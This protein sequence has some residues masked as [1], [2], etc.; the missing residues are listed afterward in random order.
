[1]KKIPKSPTFKRG[2]RV[3]T[4]GKQYGTVLRVAEL[5]ATV[6]LDKGG[7]VGRI[8]LGSL[9]KAR[10]R[11]VTE[12]APL[13]ESMQEALRRL[14]DYG[15]YLVAA[16]RHAGELRASTWYIASDF[17]GRRLQLRPVPRQ[18]VLALSRRRLIEI[19]PEYVHAMKLT[20]A[21]REVV[22]S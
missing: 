12:D 3:Y 8:I 5:E 1:M 15:P 4:I 16:P 13:S 14:R 18:T 11:I 22:K 7:Y 20:D 19:A 10:R 2:D 17:F 21:G 6:K 9:T